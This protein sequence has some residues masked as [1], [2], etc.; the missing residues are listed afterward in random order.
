MRLQEVKKSFFTEILMKSRFQGFSILPEISRKI[1]F[2]AKY[3]IKMFQRVSKSF[4]FLRVS[5]RLLKECQTSLWSISS[6][7]SKYKLY[8]IVFTF[9]GSFGE[10]LKSQLKMQHSEYESERE[11]FYYMQ[12]LK[13]DLI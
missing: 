9:I 7:R 6:F 3:I 2:S 4:Q 10:A 5:K 1:G 11:C 8:H 12:Y 13:T